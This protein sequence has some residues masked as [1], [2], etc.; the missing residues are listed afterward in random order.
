MKKH[1]ITA[2]L[3]SF[4]LLLSSLLMTGCVDG[5]YDLSKDIDMT[6]GVGK[7]LS[8]P[9]GS[10]EKIMLTELLDSTG[11]D[12]LKIDAEGDYSIFKAGEF[13]SESFEVGNMNIV[14]DPVGEKRHY[15][16]ELLD[17]SDEYANLPPWMQEEIQKQ[18]YPYKVHQ[19]IEYKTTF[20]IEQ[21]VPEEIVKLRTLSFRNDAKM[22]IKVKIYSADH[23]SDDMLEIVDRLRIGGKDGGFV[24]NVPEYVVFA[25]ESIAPGKLLLSGDVVYDDATRTLEYACEFGLKG[26]D[27]SN[28]KEGYLPVNDGMISLHETLAA[29]G[30]VDSDTVFFGFKNVTHIQSVDVEVQFDIDRMEIKSVE[31]VFSPSI[32]PLNEVVDLNLGDDLDFLK[33]AYLDFNDP[34]IF[35]S[36]VNPVDARVLADARCVGYDSNGDVIEG[37]EVNANLVFEGATT[38]NIFINRYAAT[39]PGYTTLQVPELNNLVKRIPDKVYVEVAA[40]MDDSRYSTLEL[41][42]NFDISGSYQVSVPL[43]FD[44]FRVAYTERIDKIFGEGQKDAPEGVSDVKAVSL[45][46]TVLNTIP[47]ELKP[48]VVAYDKDGNRLNGIKVIISGIISAG[49]GMDGAAVTE[50]VSSPVEIDL[51][52]VN[53]ELDKL[54]S[55]DLTVEGSGNGKFNANEYIQLKDISVTIDDEIIVDM[56]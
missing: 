1:F 5:N 2:G 8:I 44:E 28:Y 53:G 19:D 43:V 10:T 17:I 46:F 9:I 6:V 50:P 49:K 41:G 24:V 36:F 22:S 11:I 12:L 7:G 20:N 42:N 26:L 39:V 56:N 23:Q 45:D 14:I 15:D 21:S 51:S 48:S 25:D 29:S 16:F 35:V 34:R 40:R 47:L 54:Y 18:K 4:S 27:F 52:A 32:N 31:G 55:I 13:S 37:S 38:N 3:Y 30:Y 33:D